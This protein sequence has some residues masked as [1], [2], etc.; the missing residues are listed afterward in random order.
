MPT[1]KQINVYETTRP[2]LDALYE[3]MQGLCKKKPDATLS[4]GKVKLINR[5]LEDIRTVLEKEA[6]FKYLDLLDSESLPQNSDVV[7][8]LSQYTAAMDRFHSNY[9]GWDEDL[10]THRWFPSGS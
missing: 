8:I 2:L 4:E 9:H 3:E 1:K 10:R 6:D 5:L 7:L